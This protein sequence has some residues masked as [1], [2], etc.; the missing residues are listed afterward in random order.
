MAKTDEE[1]IV[2][3]ITATEEVADEILVNKQEL[4]AL[5]KRRQYTREAI[6]EIEKNCPDEKKLWITLGSTLVKM[7]RNKAL[8]LLK[9]DQ[10]VIAAEINKIRS[11]QKILVNKHRDLEQLSPYSGANLK[12]MDKKDFDALKANLPYL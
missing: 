1:K 9:N 3:I 12:P 2:E 8:E 10:V 11:D 4:V 5:D 7:E 6:R